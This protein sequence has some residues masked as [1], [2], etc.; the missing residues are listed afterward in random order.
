MKNDNWNCN[1]TLRTVG[2]KIA[3]KLADY[4]QDSK[5]Q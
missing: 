4:N 5:I 3:T 1:F 2:L